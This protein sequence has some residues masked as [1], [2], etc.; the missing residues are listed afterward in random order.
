MLHA[1]TINTS[2]RF[3]EYPRFAF[4]FETAMIPALDQLE[5]SMNVGKTLFAQIMKFISWKDFGRIVDKYNL[6]SQKFIPMSPDQD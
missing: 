5:Q 6:N 2:I 3:L 1:N 4:Y